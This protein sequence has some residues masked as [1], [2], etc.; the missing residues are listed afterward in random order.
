MP[1]LT[2]LQTTSVDRAGKCS[3]A[4]IALT[5]PSVRL[6]SGTRERMKMKRFTGYPGRR[7]YFLGG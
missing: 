3:F 4:S 2:K 6:S 7:G 5:I 1:I